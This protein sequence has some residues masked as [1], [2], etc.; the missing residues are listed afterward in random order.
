MTVVRADGLPGFA[1][2]LNGLD[3]DHDATIA[4][5]S[6]PHSN[7]ATESVNNKITML[8]ARPMAAPVPFAPQAN[9]AR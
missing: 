9:L 4:G 5:L 6:L 7:G 8:N 2:Y 1:S 3:R